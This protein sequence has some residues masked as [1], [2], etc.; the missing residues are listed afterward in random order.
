MTVSLWVCVQ[1]SST[2]NAAS[3]QTYICVWKYLNTLKKVYVFDN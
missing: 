1:Y 2:N 3:L